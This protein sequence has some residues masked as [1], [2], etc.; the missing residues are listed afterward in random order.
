MKNKKSKKELPKLTP[1]DAINESQNKN[2]I[3]NPV[4]IGNLRKENTSPIGII[5]FFIILFLVAFFL[6]KIT[7]YLNKEENSNIK[8]NLPSSSSSK[9]D[10]YLISNDGDI[11]YYEINPTESFTVDNLII[12]NINTSYSEDSYYLNFNITNNEK[13]N[14]SSKSN[15]FIELYSDSKSFIERIMLGKINISSNQTINEKVNISQKAFDNAKLVIISSKNTTDYPKVN[16]NYNE[17]IRANLI[18][19]KGNNELTYTFVDDKLVEIIENYNLDNT[20]TNFSKELEI[21][22]KKYQ[23]YNKN[24]NIEIEFSN[25]DNSFT[26]KAIFDLSKVKY[27]E[28]NDNRFYKKNTSAS[29]VKFELESSLYTCN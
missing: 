11:F 19:Q 7:E 27:K 29:I 15:Y 6:P 12:D 21:Y 2:I 16:L 13:N 25:N 9:E 23:N 26:Y 20:S 1:L 4:T 28:L 22:Q 17:G 24:E 10:S 3:P 18:C 14:F 8:I 5:L